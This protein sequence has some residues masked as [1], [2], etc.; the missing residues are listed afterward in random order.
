MYNKGVKGNYLKMGIMSLCAIY[1]HY[2]AAMTIGWIFIILFI[3]LIKEKKKILPFITTVIILAFLY[4]PWI[5]HL[6]FQLQKVNNDF[7][8]ENI[9]SEDLLFHL[10]YF[11]SVKKDWLPFSGQVNNIFMY[12]SI[13]IIACQAII[14]GKELLL[15]FRKKDRKNKLIFILLTVFILP[16]LSGLII[17]VIIKPVIVPRYMLCS[18]GPLLLCLSM[19]YV[20]NISI[21]KYAGLVI[22]SLALLLISSAIRFYGNIKFLD[23][24]HKEYKAMELFIEKHKN[25]TG[26]F[27]SEYY[28]ASALS[29]LSVFHPE[30]KYYILTTKESTENFEPFSLQKIHRDQKFD[31][32]F[33]LVQKKQ[34]EKE[35]NVAI[36]FKTALKSHFIITDSI[37]ALNMELYKMSIR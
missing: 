29:R 14:V 25:S 3:F 33:I 24:E 20:K 22:L 35:G 15:F 31:T 34:I 30:K 13:M 37:S 26:I 11:Y 2:Y 9:D 17:S 18:F 27:L 28:A 7:W 23:K 19:A 1:T 4:L 5:S 36:K 12:L 10:Y 16:V 21:R 6:I 8:I 32:E